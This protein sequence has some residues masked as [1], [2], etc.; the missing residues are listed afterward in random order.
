MS[1]PD[2]RK[3]RREALAALRR[4]QKMVSLH[5]S[6]SPAGSASSRLD[7]LPLATCRA[8]RSP[9]KQGQDQKTDQVPRRTSHVALF[10]TEGIADR[11]LCRCDRGRA[12]RA[13]MG[14]CPATDG[15]DSTRCPFRTMARVFKCDAALRR[16]CSNIV[17]AGVTEEAMEQGG[18]VNLRIAVVDH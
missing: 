1:D 6:F 3:P 2:D 12:I 10:S 18:M 5:I 14:A 4:C 7:I 15:K 9:Y 11:R 17:Q 16:R 8:P 13:R